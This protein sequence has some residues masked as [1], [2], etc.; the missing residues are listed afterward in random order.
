MTIEAK[1]VADLETTIR[2]DIGSRLGQSIPIIPKAFTNIVAAVLAA[3]FVVL[4]RYQSFGILQIFVRYASA[5]PTVLNGKTIIPLVEWGKALG[6]GEP[7]G[8][9]R[10][11]H[12]AQLG[13]L[14]PVGTLPQGTVFLR[15]VNGVLYESVAATPLVGTSVTMTVRAISDQEQKAGY[16]SHGNLVAG[17]ELELANAPLGVSRV[18]T[19]TARTVDGVEPED[20]EGSYRPRVWFAIA[21]PKQGGAPPDYW[22][23]ARRVPG[24]KGAWPYRGAT[25]NRVVVYVE[26]TAESSGS[27][28]GIPTGPQLAAVLQ[29]LQF[30][31]EGL[32]KRRPL[33]SLVTVQPIARRGLIVVVRGLVA[34]N[35]EATEAAVEA[36]CDQYLRARRPWISGLDILPV[37]HQAS[38]AGLGGVVQSVVSA[39][40]GTF[41]GIQLF[42]GVTQLDVYTLPQGELVKLESISFVS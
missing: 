7:L 41:E 28:D 14:S 42:N 38:R 17:D 36:A 21:R 32:A 27:A 26:A 11:E 16:G 24:I 31:E 3:V 29:S 37:R 40:K 12:T 4:Y 20:I 1:S 9:V 10:A 8:G 23:W 5:K 18:A 30:N 19:V 13:V 33:G 6:E 2:T 34:P 25:P 39:N 15:K 35:Q 22:S